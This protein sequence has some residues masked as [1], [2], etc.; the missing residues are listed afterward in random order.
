VTV[1]S[2]FGAFYSARNVEDACGVYADEMNPGRSR[3]LVPAAFVFA[4]VVAGAGGCVQPGTCARDGATASPRLDGSSRLT[5]SE[6]A[7]LAETPCAEPAGWDRF[8]EPRPS[9]C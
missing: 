5:A 3:R 4:A 7:E 1:K 8:G 6:E 2:G 9:A